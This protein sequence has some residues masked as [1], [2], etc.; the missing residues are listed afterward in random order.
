M[1]REYLINAIANKLSWLCAY[2]ENNVRDGKYDILKDMEDFFCYII[3]AI[4]EW[5]LKKDTNN[6]TNKLHIDLVD[7]QNKIA[8]EIKG[9]GSIKSV[10]DFVMR[11][12]QQ[13]L[14]KHIRKCFILILVA[15]S[16]KR[17]YERLLNEIQSDSEIDTIID[18][19]DVGDLFYHIRKCDLQALES[20]NQYITD[21]VFF[22]ARQDSIDRSI[23]KVLTD[24]EP[25]FKDI[26][27]REPVIEELK[28]LLKNT[29]MILLTGAAGIGKTTVA[30]HLFIALKEEADYLGWIKSTGSIEEDLLQLRLYEN[31][32]SEELRKTAIINWLAERRNKTF[33]FIDSV[34]K[35]FSEDDEHL[36]KFITTNVKIVITSRQKK[37]S[38]EIV[39]YEKEIL[40]LDNNAASILFYRFYTK[41]PEKKKQSQVYRIVDA[42]NGNPALIEIVGRASDKLAIDLQNIYK[43]VVK[44]EK[45]QANELIDSD[46]TVGIEELLF[47]TLEFNRDERKI[48]RLFSILPS[49]TEIWSMI[50]EWACL[51]KS[52]LDNLVAMGFIS[53]IR[54]NYI[55]HEL[56]K[57]SIY[58]KFEIESNNEIDFDDYGKLLEILSDT[59]TYLNDDM[60]EIELDLKICIPV[61]ICNYVI[62]QGMFSIEIARLLNSIAI[63]LITRNS[64]ELSL[65]LLTY[66]VQRSEV[67]FGNHHRVT[68]DGFR[69][70]AKVYSAIS[71][72][73]K[74]LKYSMD[75]LSIFEQ[76][77]DDKACVCEQYYSIGSIYIDKNEFEKGAEYLEKAMHLAETNIDKDSVLASRILFTY[78]DT[79]IKRGDYKNALKYHTKAKSIREKMSQTIDI[80]LAA[81]YNAIALCYHEMGDYRVA[82]P[83]YMKSYEL[84]VKERGC[85]RKST[86]IVKNNLRSLLALASDVGIYDFSGYTM[87]EFDFNGLIMAKGKFQS[88]NLIRCIFNNANLHH[89]IFQK[90]KIIGCSFRGA[91]LYKVS[92]NDCIMNNSDFE[93]ANLKNADFVGAIIENINLKGAYLRNACMTTEQIYR[94][95]LSDRQISQIIVVR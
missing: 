89:A 48:L 4:F 57:E 70:L 51:D 56:I 27:G 67:V 6:K 43:S 29:S 87:E 9:N 25:I 12:K 42:L 14:F 31:I 80:P 63:V 76:C 69:G 47:R 30:E 64:L 26:I 3:N 86:I 83:Y 95:K 2:I 84:L 22:Q 13:G 94:L 53:V 88:S 82:Y 34:E 24:K 21:S 78:A 46:T 81:S 19:W 62:Q 17:G 11:G 65:K 77:Y 35:K 10:I 38:E 71:E 1:K 28:I 75:A 15:E 60:D 41:D 5:N 50:V 66:S 90:S 40:K 8:V 36:L 54:S 92:F 73:D 68:A 55:M 39:L 23:P 72:H 74:A 32:H 7:M 33:L 91:E 49:D 18:I 61:A 37:L 79:F 16:K 93:N 20:I 52:V 45:I 44:R 58:R 85:K 59:S